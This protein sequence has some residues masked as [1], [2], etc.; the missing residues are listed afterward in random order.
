MKQLKQV[1]C[2][3]MLCILGLSV[4]A[5]ADNITSLKAQQ[6]FEKKVLELLKSNSLEELREYTESIP[7]CVY[8]EDGTVPPLCTVNRIDKRDFVTHVF[9]RSIERGYKDFTVVNIDAAL[10]GGF[11]SFYSYLYNDFYKTLDVSKYRNFYSRFRNSWLSE[12]VEKTMIRIWQKGDFFDKY[13]HFSCVTG[14]T[15]FTTIYI[16]YIIGIDPFKYVNRGI[17]MNTHVYNGGSERVYRILIEMKRKASNLDALDLFQEVLHEWFYS[18]ISY[19]G[20]DKTEMEYY[21]G[22]KQEFMYKFLSEFGWNAFG[23]AGIKPSSWERHTIK[24]NVRACRTVLGYKKLYN[25]EKICSDFENG[26]EKYGFYYP[27]YVEPSIEEKIEEI[28]TQF[29]EKYMMAL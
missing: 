18:I 26:A 12:K 1:L 9:H 23:K 27:P 3:I 17:L 16:S 6:E 24:L 22:T 10:Y 21:K 15:L 14:E 5:K 8:L 4:I 28:N 13:N 19:E 11:E 7:D 2:V 20:W 25:L 29:K